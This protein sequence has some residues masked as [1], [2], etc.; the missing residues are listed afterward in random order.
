MEAIKPIIRE[1]EEKD[2]EQ[3]LCIYNDVVK[4]STAVY[5]YE[6]RSLDVQFDWYHSKQKSKFP[7]LIAEVESRIAGY[8]SYGPFRAWPAYF[9]TVESSI[10]I[11]PLYRGKN[12]GQSLMSNLIQ[13]AKD[14]EY[15]TIIAAIDATN[16]PSLK[17]HSN[18]G[19]VQTA[20][21]REVGWK[22]NR[23]LDLIFM[24]L[25]LH[26]KHRNSRSSD[27]KQKKADQNL[28]RKE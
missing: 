4:T 20:V 5:E 11:A 14:K 24:Q 8:C 7:I 17:L 28:V 16:L 18:L 25:I 10:Y 27:D 23:W 2:L 6:P 9:R 12:L 26:S 15:H 13:R 22:F 1:A 21:L 3:I 19:F